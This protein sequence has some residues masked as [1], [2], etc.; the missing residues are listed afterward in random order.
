MRDMLNLNARPPSPESLTVVLRNCGAG[1]KESPDPTA[2]VTTQF[3]LH[4][5]L[6]F[7]NPSPQSVMKVFWGRGMVC[8]EV[9]V[10][11]DLI[12]WAREGQ[13]VCFFG[14]RGCGEGGRRRCH[15]AVTPR[16]SCCCP[17]SKS[18]RPDPAGPVPWGCLASPSQSPCSGTS[19]WWTL[20]GEWEDSDQWFYWDDPSN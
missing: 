6:V 15:E 17:E 18:W 9:I 14:G 8:A 12:A 11:V 5:S 19:W 1:K 10:E 4:G 3:N 13:K 7:P 16:L 2:H 20:G